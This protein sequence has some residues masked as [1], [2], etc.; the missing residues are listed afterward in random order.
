[1]K[2]LL[3]AGITAALMFG[4]VSAAIA[5]PGK[6]GHEDPRNDGNENNNKGKCTA[7]FNGEKNGHTDPDDSDDN[8][9]LEAIYD[10]CDGLIKGQP[11][12]GRFGFCFDEDTDKDGKTCEAEEGDPPPAEGSEVPPLP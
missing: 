6:A 10:S 7:Y 2:K 8:A 1:M 4:G 9:L 12:H 11:D 3:A 5:E